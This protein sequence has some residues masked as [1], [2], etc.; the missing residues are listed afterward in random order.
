MFGT[1][2]ISVCTAMH[3]YVFWRA[4]SVPL[5]DRHVPRWVFLTLCVG[6][7]VLFFLGRVVG[8]RHTGTLAAAVEL[9][10]MNWMAMLFLTFVCVLAMDLVTGFGFLRPR[11]APTLRGWALVAGAVLSVIALVQGLRPPVVQ[12]YEV[13]LSGLPRQMEGRVIVAMSDLHIGSLLGGR[14]LA[15]RVAQ[16]QAERPDMVVLLGDQFEGHGPAQAELLPVLR[17]LTAPLGVWAV[18]GNHEFHGRGNTSLSLLQEAGIEVLRDRW[19]E[20]RPGLILAGV[21]DLTTRRR[22]GQQGDPFFQALEGRPPGVTILLSHRP[23]W[24]DTAA[25]AGVGLMLCGH[26]HGGQIW[27]FNYVVRQSY[28]LLAG[29]YEVGAMTVI[30]SR[31]AGTWGPRMRL[32][33]PG[34]I[35]RLTLRGG[36]P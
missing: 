21:D 22:V 26:T 25:G 33:Q 10:G 31:G 36:E 4:A 17:G 34:E 16:V 6:L 28:S 35:L 12:S 23:R 19:A 30:V 32:W 11:L 15:A 24:A 18:S 14:W 13:R 27:P 1:I 20:V 7:W 9:V 5:V 3:L 2:L 29:R 8:H